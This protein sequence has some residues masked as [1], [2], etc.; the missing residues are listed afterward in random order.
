MDEAAREPPSPAPAQANPPPPR[1]RRRGRWLAWAAVLLAVLLVAAIAG[2]GLGLRWILIEPAGTRWAVEQAARRVP[3]M[4]AEGVE[5]ALLGDFRTEVL[6]VDLGSQRLLVQDLRWR[7]LSLTDWQWRAPYLCLH[8]QA[9]SAARVVLERTGTP[10]PAEPSPPP[11]SLHLPVHLAIDRVAVDELALPGLAV[12]VRQLRAESLR[13]GETH[14]A[15]RLLAAWNGLRLEASA[16]LQAAAPMQLKADAQ[17]MSDPSAA[18]GGLLPEWARDVQARLHAEGPLAAFAARTELAMQEQRLQAQGTVAPFEPMPLTQLEARFDRLD[19]ARLLAPVTPLAPATLLS[20]EARAA[21]PRGAGEPLQLTLQLRNAAPGRWDLRRLPLTSLELAAGGDADRWTVERALVQ[22]ADSQGRPAGRLEGRGAYADGR[23]QADL[24]VVALELPALDGRA[25]PVRLSGPIKA[26]VQRPAAAG[27]PPFERAALE[28]QLQGRLLPAANAR[29]ITAAAPRELALELQARATPGRYEIAK[30]E[31]RA[32]GARLTVDGVGE[33]SADGWAVRGGLRAQDFDPAAWWP[34]PAGTPWAR[35][36]HRINAEARLTATWPAGAA[37]AEWRR[38]TEAE[39]E[40]RFFDSLLAGQAL[41]L[42]AQGRAQRGLWQ[43][44]AEL[45]AGSNTARLEL[46]VRAPAPGQAPDPAD[47]VVLAMDAP[48]LRELE[49]LAQLAGLPALQGSARLDAR[50]EGGL[51][52]WWTDGAPPVGLRTEGQASLQSLQL[53]A[54]GVQGLQGQ[55]RAA[56]QQRAPIE[57]KLQ[58]EGMHLPGV[59]VPQAEFTAEGDTLEHRVSLEARLQPDRRTQAAA[60]ANEQQAAGAPS[61]VTA[62]ADPAATPLDLRVQLQGSLR[63]PSPGTSQ[64]RAVVQTLSLTPAGAAAQREGALALIDAR[65]L[66]LAWERSGARHQWSLAPGRLQVL[67]ATLAWREARWEQEGELRRLAADGHVEPLEIAPLLKRFQPDFGWAGDL[68]IGGRFLVRSVPEVTA[69]IELQRAGGDL[70]IVEF[71]TV[72]NLGLREVAL[73][74]QADQGVWRLTQRVEGSELGR[75][76]GEQTLRASP[77]AMWPSPEAPLAG[78]LDVEVD[79]LAAWGMWVPA[80]WRLG[81]QAAAHLTLAGAFGSPYL[82]GELEGRR[83]AVRNALEGVALQDGVVRVL[84]QGESARIETFRFSGG[85]GRVELTGSARLGAAPQAQLQVVAQR[86]AVLTRVD[87]RVVVSGDAS[88]QLQPEQ[89]VV[90]GR[91]KADEGLIDISRADAPSLS[92]DVVVRRAGDA[93]LDEAAPAPRQPGPVARAL[94]LDVV[95]N[96]GERFRLRGRGIATRLEGELRLTSPGGRLAAHGEIR[97]VDGEYEAYGQELTIERGVLTFVG[98]IDNPRLDIVAVRPRMETRV[99]V[100]VT[101]SALSPRVTLFS[102]PDL[103]DTEKLALLVTGRS[104]DTLA[105]N[106]TLIL[107]RAA[108]AL[109]AGDGS[110]DSNN[111]LKN[112]PLDELSVRQSDGAVQE[113]IVSLGKRIS[114]RVYVGYERSLSSTVGSWQLIYRIAQRFTLRAQTG[115]DAGVDLVWIFRWN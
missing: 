20:G 19:L 104:Y 88:L 110:G 52:G 17:I 60:R 54:L 23:L 13:L 108:W 49:P 100:T 33:A 107:Q 57:A 69:L 22:A 6:R 64:W 58:A 15:E 66:Q 74:L 28:A 43:G 114:D 112:L 94:D 2:I 86:F 71:G 89:V 99:G 10:P 87:R 26:D 51:G 102:D 31:L 90:R 84:F 98:A 95:L 111:P 67:G 59:L 96:L 7:S 78:R 32:A 29:G 109:L 56:F 38:R 62:R 42:Q 46:R 1:R 115:E 61:A 25:P 55:W 36:P 97:T 44:Q 35:G 76:F 8:A 53:G 14:G 72:Q 45:Q 113:T 11:T 21:L 47:R 4:Q 65:E 101:G 50:A 82:T 48:D 18:T 103:P 40:A 27:G 93:P 77:Q 9:L 63:D 34:G 83:L 37:P 68:R 92:E 3:G 85:D 24:Q 73:R 5:G 16:A 75:I 41:A 30:A 81:G 91:L 12:P 39:L 79:N 70:Q 80:G 106:Q 105:G